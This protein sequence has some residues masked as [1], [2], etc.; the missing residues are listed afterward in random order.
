[1]SKVN[2]DPRGSGRLI[3]KN[4][5][6]GAP[7][8]IGAPEDAD[9]PEER[10]TPEEPDAPA[11]PDAPA[12]SDAK[13]PRTPFYRR[14]APIIFFLLVCLA[15]IAGGIYWLHARHFESTDDA[16]IDGHT[17]PISPQVSALVAAIHIDD[18]QF[19]HKGDLLVELDPTDYR[20]ALA[21]AQGSEASAKGKLEQART[22][23][24][25]A[26]SAVD[27]AKAELDAAQVN[28]ENANRDLQ[29]Y[30]GLDER[31]KSQQQLDNATMT[32]K[33]AAAQVQQARAKL[34]TVQ[35]QVAS[36]MANVI[37]A[38]GDYQKAQADTA[39]AQINLSYCRIVAPEDGRVTNKNV[40]A[41]IYVTSSSQLFVLVP[42]EVWVVANFKETQLDHMQP[43]QPVKIKV[44]AYPDREFH[45]TVQSIQAGTGSRFS[46]IPAENA[47]GNFVKV[48]QRVP[49]KITFDSDVNSDE[50]HLL[51]PGMSVEPIVQVREGS[52]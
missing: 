8:E 33:T 45:G 21:Q 36:A 30:Q 46:V 15:A 18:N 29:R 14:P 34:A 37:A 24:A 44:D 2:V 26:Q 48:V 23:V 47:T 42:A 49:V 25:A 22:G 32:Q 17:I 43:G 7:A 3:R 6:Q 5:D 31:A 10:D 16:Y 20:A 1:M 41:G 39:R 4:G 19:V 35:A 28:F 9:A 12:D 27:Q 38:D 50:K 40:D 11:K 51:S 52:Y 13:A